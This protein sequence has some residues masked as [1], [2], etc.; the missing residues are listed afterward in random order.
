MATLKALKRRPRRFPVWGALLP[1]SFGHSYSVEMKDFKEVIF[2]VL[3]GEEQPRPVR[4]KFPCP[5]QSVDRAVSFRHLKPRRFVV[6]FSEYAGQPVLPERH[7]PGHN[8]FL[9]MLPVQFVSPN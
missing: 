7:E 1:V 8:V 5:D 3:L 9:R 6:L 4:S 2:A